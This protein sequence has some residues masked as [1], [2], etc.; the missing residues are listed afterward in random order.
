MRY[1][2]INAHLAEINGFPVEAHIGR[3]TVE[4]PSMGAQAEGL[5]RQVLETMNPLGQELQA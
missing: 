1:G 4:I 5:F 2:S 3:T